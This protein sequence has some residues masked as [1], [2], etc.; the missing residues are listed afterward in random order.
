MSIPLIICDIDGTLANIDHRVHHIHKDEPDWSAFKQGQE[1]DA[2]IRPIIDMVRIMW[3]AGYD[4]VFCTGRMEDEREV[5]AKWLTD[6]VYF[7]VNGFDGRGGSRLYMR[8]QDDHSDDSDMKRE[9]LKEIRAEYSDHAIQFAIED[10][11]RVVDMWRS[12]G[13]ICLQCAPGQF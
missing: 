9:L 7:T 6:H 8:P 4:V 12:E 1:N 5:T 2:P 11:Q 10:R 13:I 3:R